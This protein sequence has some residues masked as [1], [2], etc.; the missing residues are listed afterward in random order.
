MAQE[1]LFLPQGVW[2]ADYSYSRKERKNIF[3]SGRSKDSI[4]ERKRKKEGIPSGQVSGSISQEST[5][6]TLEFHYGLTRKFNLGLK[7]PHYSKKRNADTLKDNQGSNGAF[8][9]A[10]R[11]ASAEGMGDIEIAFS[12]R[13]LYTDEH[14]VRIGLLY[15]HDNAPY[16]F[17]NSRELPIGTG[18]R[19]VSLFFHWIRYAIASNLHTKFLFL[20]M[21][22]MD[23]KTKDALAEKKTIQRSNSRKIHL[24]VATNHRE[25]HYGFG[26][27]FSDQAGTVIGGVGQKDGSLSYT[28]ELFFDYGNLYRLERGAIASPWRAGFRYGSV[29]AGSNAYDTTEIGFRVARFF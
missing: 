16:N 27:R 23:G 18:C 5:E 7:I 21:F 22:T 9:E 2:R 14:D 13:W 3:E 1:V 28:Y 17:E 4:L 19:E 10:N 6:H 20:E 11:S 12:G 26:I 24:T 8:I 29:V 15:N 25:W